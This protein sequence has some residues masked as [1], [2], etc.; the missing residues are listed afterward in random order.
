MNT[1]HMTT[2]LPLFSLASLSSLFMPSCECGEDGDSDNLPA[3]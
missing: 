1:G 3:F 2:N